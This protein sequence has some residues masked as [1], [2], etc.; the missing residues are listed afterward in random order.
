M[1]L[2]KYKTCPVCGTQNPPNLF[3]CRHCETDLTGVPIVSSVS[4]PAP[5]QPQTSE[6]NTDLVRVCEC[7]A[8]NPPQAR[9]CSACGEDISDILPTRRENCATAECSYHLMTE[10]GFSA[11]IRKPVTVVGREAELKEY[12]QSKMFVSR[13]HAKLTM[14]AGEVFIENLSATNKT[15]LNNVEIPD[16]TPTALSDGDE[17]GLGGKVVNGSRQ[18]DA[19]YFVY[20]VKL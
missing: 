2:L 9:K 19:A 4:E 1:D 18:D 11:E 5:A 7:G 8:M 20:R 3:E 14:V 13:H 12:L 16:G 10:D 6:P 15:F 17:I